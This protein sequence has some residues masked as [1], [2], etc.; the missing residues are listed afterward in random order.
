MTTLNSDSD[1]GRLSY[2]VTRAAKATRQDLRGT[3]GGSDMS[4]FRQH[5]EG[6]SALVHSIVKFTSML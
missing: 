4:L 1:E 2:T 3:R 6:R 5:Q